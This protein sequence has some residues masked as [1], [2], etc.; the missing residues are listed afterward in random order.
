MPKTPTTTRA[1][2]TVTVTAS[3]KVSVQT[4]TPR[5]LVPFP[6]NIIPRPV[7]EVA[8]GGT[9]VLTAHAGINVEPATDEVKAIGQ[10]LADRINPSTGYET[11]VQG[12]EIG[13]ALG[14]IYLT[15]TGADPALGD[16]GYELTITPELVKLV[17]N[18]PAGLFHGVQTIRQLLPPAIDSASIQPGPWILGTGTITDF[19]RFAWRG[20]MLDV[21]RHFFNV[22]D[23][24]RYID[25]LAYYK[26]NR[27]HLHLSDDQGWRIQI[28]SWPNLAIH[29]GSLEVGGGP[30]GYYSQE[31]YAN[32]VNYARSRYIT[33]IPEI[34][35][36][37]HT[38]AAL[39]SYPELNCGGIAPE[40]FTG[41]DVGFSSFCINKDITYTFLEDVI[42]EL[43]GM[44]PGAYIHIGG[45]EA[46]AT[47]QP[48]YINF[49]KRAQSIVAANGKQV[50]GWEEIAQA[51]LLPGS[52]VQHW[53]LTA[54]LAAQAIQQGARVIMSPADKAYLDMKYTAATA[55][56]LEWAGTINLEKGYSWDPAKLIAGVTEKDILGVEAPLWSETLKTM[57]DIEYMAFPRLPGYAEIGWSP[58]SRRDWSEYKKRLGTHGPR[59]EALGVHFYRS[60]EIAWP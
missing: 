40:L 17:A 55:L 1:K 49:V 22:R 11:K 59:L 16:E 8:T 56:G 58:Q 60:P 10:Y 21:A 7:S 19:P 28:N 9:F 25:L 41:T 33:I 31:D 3:A 42:G 50:V 30:G 32:I 36:P 14:N 54:G 45:D 38:T 34:D 27:L 53:N 46:K 13:P 4:S 20:A 57:E 48:D 35:M 5:N 26:I 51:P 43:A 47:N 37:G 18:Q 12:T 24:S 44:T 6:V 52:I 29:G 39:A 15:L 2:P 23:V